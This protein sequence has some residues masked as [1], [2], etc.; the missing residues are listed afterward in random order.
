MIACFS[1]T[2]NSRCVADKLQDALG[3]ELVRFAPGQML[4]P[5]KTNLRVNDGRIIW[6]TPV[7]AWGIPSAMQRII[8]QMGLISADTNI[9]HYLVLT[10]G[11]DVGY[12][13]KQWRRLIRRRHWSARAAFSVQ[14]PNNYTFLPGFDIDP[15]DV[16]ERK[17][18][19]MPGR[20]AA[21]IDAIENDDDIVDVVRGSFAWFKS[22][23]LRAMFVRFCSST[24]PFHTTDACTGCGKCARNCAVNTIQM[25]N[26]H[27]QWGR[28]CNI[29]TRCYNSCPM[30]AI[31]YG[32]ATKGKGQYMC[33]G[34]HLKD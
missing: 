9:K 29:C 7:H 25:V 19:A 13:D 33:P 2:G 4:H 30:H 11:D 32:K 1:G 22:S 18:Q 16:A 31:A 3:D 6:V 15:K 27:P 34:Y 17:L 10:C 20:V 14:M 8:R 26:G 5:K 21:I 23:V 28:P 24:K 12:A